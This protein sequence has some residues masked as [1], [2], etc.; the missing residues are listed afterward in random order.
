MRKRISFVLAVLVGLSL[1]IAACQAETVSA[2]QVGKLAPEFQL[3]SLDGQVVSL[4]EL[5]GRPVMLNF[6]ATWCSPCI[7]EMPHIQAAYE[8][9]AADLVIL[10]IYIGDSQSQ[11]EDFMQQNK[12]SFPVMLDED[13]GVAEM[14][15]VRGIPT[16]VFIDRDGVIRVMKVGAYSS[17]AAIERDLSKIIPGI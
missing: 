11:V 15:N 14:Y 3:P 1:V 16:T 12:L 9:Y 6:W 7:G 13:A 2:P 8:E 4:E 5:R 17:K 10:A